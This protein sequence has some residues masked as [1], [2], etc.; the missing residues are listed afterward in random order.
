[1]LTREAVLNHRIGVLAR[2][3]K[4][5]KLGKQRERGQ[6]RILRQTVRAPAGG[7]DAPRPRGGR[8][9]IENMSAEEIEAAYGNIPMGRFK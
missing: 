4:A 7:S 5:E 6:R 3:G 8:R 9:S 2:Q 1:M